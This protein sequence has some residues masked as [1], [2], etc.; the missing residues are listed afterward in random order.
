MSAMTGSID[1]LI[2]L[3]PTLKGIYA[4]EKYG[5]KHFASVGNSGYYMESI[6]DPVA[7]S[8]RAGWKNFYREIE[9]RLRRKKY[10]RRGLFIPISD[11]LTYPPARNVRFYAESA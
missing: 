4:E 8:I 6:I 1:V 2:K 9:S 11:I 3:I 7:I 10:S 5:L